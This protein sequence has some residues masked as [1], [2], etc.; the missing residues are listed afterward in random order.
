MEVGEGHTGPVEIPGSGVIGGLRMDDYG[1]M[2]I[3][4]PRPD[5]MS[6]TSLTAA[7]ASNTICCA[8]GRARGTPNCGYDRAGWRDA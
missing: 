2:A 5:C 7:A 1:V 6:R 3:W 8:S 4:V